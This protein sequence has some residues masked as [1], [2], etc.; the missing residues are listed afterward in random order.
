MN[1]TD[2]IVTSQPI[3]YV[4]LLIVEIFSILCTL[5]I[6]IYVGV[7]RHTMI[8]K[9]L[10]NHALILII[11]ISFAYNTLDLPFTISSYRLG[12]DIFRSKGFCQWWYWID[13]TLVAMSLLVTSIASI[14]R[15]VLIFRSHLL[16]YSRTR[17]LIHYLPLLVCLIYSSLFYLIVVFVYPCETYPYDNDNLFCPLPCYSNNTILISIDWILNCIIP[18]I[19]I[20]ISH[21]ILVSW[22]ILSMRTINRRQI[23][24]RRKHRRI[25]LQLSTFAMLFVIGWT[26]STVVSVFHLFSLNNLIDYAPNLTYVYYMNYFICPLQPFICLCVLKEPVHFLKDQCKQI[27]RRSNNIHV[28]HT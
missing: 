13:Y 11:M 20:I 5:F 9:A 10:H 22:M 2:G 4:L 6:L 3:Q 8:S 16:R 17:C 26:P 14:Q 18:L 25:T 1:N 23:L 15:Y 21:L 24:M 27:L 28:V 19:I 12:Y 7:Y